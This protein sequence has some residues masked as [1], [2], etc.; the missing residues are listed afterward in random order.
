MRSLAIA[1]SLALSGALALALAQAPPSSGTT[2]FVLDGNRTYAELVFLR[3]DGSF[4]RALAYVDMG[5]PSFEVREPLYSELRL[6]RGKALTFRI[7]EMPV[8]VPASLVRRDDSPPRSLGSE[9]K[10]E[11]LLPAGVLQR[12]EVVIDYGG[13]SLTLARPGSLR[14]AGVPVPFRRKEETGLIAVDASID[15]KA[16]A[17]TI[18]N[19][20]AY[21]W[22]RRDVVEGWLAA[23]PDWE[24]GVGAVGPSNMMMAGDGAEAAGILV[25]VPRVALGSLAL[26]V[27]GALG[28]G[29][30]RSPDPKVALF[31][32][33][34]T[35]NA[36]PVIGWI[37]GN[38]LKSFRITVDYPKGTMFWERQAD[39]DGGEL[40]Q[41][42]L[43]L[44][45]EN[46]EFVVDAIARKNGNATGPVAAP[47][48]RLIRIGEL[49][50]RGA[51]WGAVYAA[52]HGKPGETRAL[53]LERNGKRFPVAAPVTAF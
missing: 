42:G 41:V 33:Y 36:V 48:D 45:F 3:P 8:E 40:D 22:F 28:A 19:G 10:V 5:S 52:M 6:E 29:P 1:P 26:G 9:L 50:T 2:R 25:R 43:T 7:G 30:G 53:I 11:A 51:T 39:P 21:T 14:P 20:S 4:H 37:G 35:K 13:R 44:R 32:W 16:Y 18:D 12:F 23:H 34:S 47:G 46:G 15:G 24:R 49:K 27:V 38:V 17:V 31:D